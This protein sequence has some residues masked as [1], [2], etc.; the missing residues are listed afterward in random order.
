MSLRQTV[1]PRRHV[2]FDWG[3]FF[4][5]SLRS[6]STTASVV[7]SS[8]YLARAL[9]RSID[10]SQ[11][12]SLVEVGVGTGAVTHELLRRMR[13]DARLYALDINPRF[14]A[15]LRRAF[16]DRRLIPIAGSAEDLGKILAAR[17]VKNA[18]AIVSSL[19]LSIMPK[20]VRER[21]LQEM[22]NQLGPAG[23]FSQFQYIHAR[24]APRCLNFFGVDAFCEE[25]FLRQH[26]RRVSI[27]NVL[28]NF[29][30]ATVYT[31]W[32]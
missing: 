18:D 25:R 5:E 2:P 31:C 23:V 1:A 11:A 10:F 6:F 19:G 32:A 14:I 20:P 24:H 15:Y 22:K 4:N 3:L 29:L 8:P 17:G 30:P 21:I 27:H 7:P 16:D 12:T 28:R 26:F 13:P 9:L